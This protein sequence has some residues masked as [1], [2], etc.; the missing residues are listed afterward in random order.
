MRPRI[1]NL[2]DTN[3]EDFGESRVRSYINTSELQNV[4]LAMVDIN[5]ESEII[6]NRGFDT[7]YYIL[8]GSGNFDIDGTTYRV[9]KYDLVIIPRNTTCKYEGHMRILAVCSPRW[10]KD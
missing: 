3:E 8:E 2:S 4:S 6:K 5:D 10:R 7:M 9:K 1:I